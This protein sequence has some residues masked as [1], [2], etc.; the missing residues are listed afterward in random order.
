MF[1]G[2]ISRQKFTQMVKEALAQ[3]GSSMTSAEVDLLFRAL[4]TNKCEII[5]STCFAPPA[6]YKMRGAPQG[7]PD[8]RLPEAEYD[9]ARWLMCRLS[10]NIQ[11]AH[12][13]E[14]EALC[15]PLV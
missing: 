12:D 2:S 6:I 4:D 8:H 3:N 1:A 11:S 13:A 15:S 5:L 7:T 14:R 10:C 9:G